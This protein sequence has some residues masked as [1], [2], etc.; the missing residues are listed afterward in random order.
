M[1]KTKI[2]ITG[3]YESEGHSITF[4]QREDDCNIYESYRVN[5]EEVTSH[6]VCGIENATR[7]QE[8]Y[9][10]LGYDKIS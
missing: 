3:V 1:S 4:T 8:K 7:Y 9:I 2:D 6:I 10:K 5:G